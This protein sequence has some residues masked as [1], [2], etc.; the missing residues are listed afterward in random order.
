MATVAGVTALDGARGAVLGLTLVVLAWT[1]AGLVRHQRQAQV[2]RRRRADVAR[3][4]S[5]LAAQLRVG[6]VPGVALAMAAKDHQVLREARDAQDLGGDVVRVWRS[7]AHQPGFAGL[8]DLARAWQVSARTGAP[9]SATLEQVAPGRPP[10]V[11]VTDTAVVLSVG[12]GDGR[13]LSMDFTR[14]LRR[15]VG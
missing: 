12:A 10:D 11:S 2:Q 8:L 7:Q 13:R 4:C 3:A 5:A 6:Q 15:K 14:I 1:V 9:M